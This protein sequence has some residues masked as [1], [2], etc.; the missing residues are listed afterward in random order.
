MIIL[1]IEFSANPQTLMSI[2]SSSADEIK[3]TSRGRIK[4]FNESVI[5]VA[6]S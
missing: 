2:F 6:S 3:I 4:A 5:F 1:K